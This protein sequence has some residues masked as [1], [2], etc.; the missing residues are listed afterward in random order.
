[1]P[2]TFAMRSDSCAAMA[3]ADRVAFAVRF[4]VDQQP[5]PLLSVVLTPSSAD[6]RR[7]ARDVGVFWQFA[8][9][10]LLAVGHRTV[11]GVLRRLRD[12]LD[13]PA[14]L[15]REEALRHREVQRRGE[16][17]HGQQATEGEALV[18]QR[19]VE[20][21]GVACRSRGP[22]SAPAF[23]AAGAASQ[24]AGAHHRRERERDGERDDDGHREGHRELVEHR[25]RPRR[26]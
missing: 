24:Q 17:Q 15:H 20:A 6:E 3:W 19:P 18:A 22:S 1:M 12:A 10:G 8:G 13:H 23:V 16:A 2:G 21:A 5:R 26:P 11:G 7:Q 9:E 14:V 25:G 4:Q